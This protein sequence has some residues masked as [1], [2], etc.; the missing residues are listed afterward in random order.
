VLDEVHETVGICARDTRRGGVGGGAGGRAGIAKGIGSRAA[1][2]DGMT[3]VPGG[4]AGRWQ[5]AEFWGHAPRAFPVADPAL[6]QGTPH[7]RQAEGFGAPAECDTL[8]DFRDTRRIIASPCTID[9]R[10]RPLAG[11]SATRADHRLSRDARR[12]KAPSMMNVRDHAWFAPL[13]PPGTRVGRGRRSVAERIFCQRRSLADHRN[14]FNRW[15]P[16]GSR[17]APEETGRSPRPAPAR[18]QPDFG[19]PNGRCARPAKAPP[20]TPSTS[21]VT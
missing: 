18:S 9:A 14:I 3:C 21:P 4:A 16:G 7:R 1:G 12:P 11:L 17:P 2:L 19:V 13:R 10:P 6:Q 15:P 5:G 8:T 20:L